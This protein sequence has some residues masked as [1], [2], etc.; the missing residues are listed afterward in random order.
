MNLTPSPVEAQPA[1]ET[2]LAES[3]LRQLCAQSAAIGALCPCDPLAWLA[4]TCECIRECFDNKARCTAA[5]YAEVDD[6]GTRL[7]MLS[8]SEG[9]GAAHDR[10]I[11]NCIKQ[12]STDGLFLGMPRIDC[13]DPGPVVRLRSELLSEGRWRESKLFDE[14]ARLDL[15]E[16]AWAA[17]RTQGADP[18]RIIALQLDGAAPGWTPSETQRRMLDA[19]ACAVQSAY[20]NGPLAEQERQGALLGMLSPM[21]RR[22]AP[23]LASGLSET[24]IADKLG[25]S[26][27]TVHE[28]AKSIYQHWHVSSRRE[29]RDLWLGRSQVDQSAQQ[30]A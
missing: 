22:V 3:A 26:K 23:M 8:A 14:R 25:R 9:Y 29:L 21:R 11:S 19:L 7:E 30:V 10:F 16:F 20:E 13:S 6:R 1:R 18:P 28:H 17:I 24:E 12:Q 27:H 4:K 2:P 15:H 5:V